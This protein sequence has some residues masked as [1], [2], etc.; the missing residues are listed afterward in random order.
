M[1][2]IIGQYEIEYL[3][4]ALGTECVMLCIGIKTP[5]QLERWMGGEAVTCKHQIRSLRQL[6]AV[7]DFLRE[8]GLDD[9]SIT[10]WFDVVPGNGNY[11]RVFYIRDNMFRLLCEEASLEHQQV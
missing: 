9:E 10:H 4:D 2:R 1:I 5:Q 6:I 7:V 3:V 11:Q 8:Q